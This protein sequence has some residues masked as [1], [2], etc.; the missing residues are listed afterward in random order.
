MTTEEFVAFAK[1]ADH[2]IYP[3]S[4]WNDVYA[5]NE[6]ILDEFVSVSNQNVYDYQG[7]GS[8]AWFEQRFV[9]YDVVLNDFCLVA[10]T[11]QS[12]LPANRRF[13]LRNVFSEPVE[14]LGTCEDPSAALEPRG[15][16]WSNCNFDH[17]AQ[18]EE[19]AV[20]DVEAG[21]GDEDEDAH[22]GGDLDDGDHDDGEDTKENVDNTSD[23]VS[24]GFITY[25]NAPLFAVVASLVA[26]YL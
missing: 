5:E 16:A 17:A 25:N 10:G 8:N 2:W 12:T 1:D 13:W 3:N 9:E 24:S 23:P 14:T 4:N 11:V 19:E 26:L 18:H 21:H 7:Q 22:S 6:A 15:N 20:E